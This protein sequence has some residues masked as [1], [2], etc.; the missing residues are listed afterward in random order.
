MDSLG[1]RGR[2]YPFIG[3]ANMIPYPDKY[4]N[5]GRYLQ[6]RAVG[7]YTPPS[8][9]PKSPALPGCAQHGHKKGGCVTCALKEERS[10]PGARVPEESFCIGERNI[11]YNVFG[12]NACRP[13]PD[14]YYTRGRYLE[15]ATR[16]RYEPTP[17][18]PNIQFMPEVKAVQ[19]RKPQ[20]RQEEKIPLERLKTGDTF[21]IGE[22][23][24]FYPFIGSNSLAPYPDK[25][26]NLGR[27]EPMGARNLGDGAQKESPLLAFKPS[28]M[29]LPAKPPSVPCVNNPNIFCVTC[30]KTGQGGRPQTAPSGGANRIPGPSWDRPGVLNE[31]IGGGYG[32]P[33]A[34]SMAPPRGP[35]EGGDG[36]DVKWPDRAP[37][38]VY[39]PKQEPAIK[40]TLLYRLPS[41]DFMDNYGVSL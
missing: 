15:R 9:G 5:M 27:Y 31:K 41:L 14:K 16:Q 33:W 11:H 18:P 26:I 29:P 1:D 32:P 40:P 3:S 30:A 6:A 7:D 12:S 34:T 19:A 8:S 23:D 37:P 35:F 36:R 38:R 24:L 10:K 13:F 39:P 2:H 21:C 25:Y 22:R 28:P 17:T 4:Y 20:A